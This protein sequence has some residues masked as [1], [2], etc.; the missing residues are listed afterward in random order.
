MVS[1]SKKPF[2]DVK[3]HPNHHI[4]FAGNL[5]FR[6]SK[7]RPK[8]LYSKSAYAVGVSFCRLSFEYLRRI[9]DD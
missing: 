8:K 5:D 7:Y 2:E 6:S 4:T 3:I 1:Q 9:F